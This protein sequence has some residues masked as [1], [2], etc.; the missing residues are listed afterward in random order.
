MTGFLGTGN[1]GGAIINGM[2]S[3]GILKPSCITVYD[4]DPKASERFLK[5]GCCI[6]RNE[7]TLAELCDIIFLCIKPQVFPD[8][9]AKLSSLD[10]SDKL[11]V[12]IAAGVPTAKIRSLLGQQVKIIRVMP[13]APLMVSKG[14]SAIYA[15][16]TVE[17]DKKRFVI[18]VFSKLGVVSLIDESQMNEI[19]CVN[20]SSPAYVYYFVDAMVESAVSQGID[21]DEAFKLICAVFEGSI[22]MLRNSSLSPKELIKMVCSPGGTTIESIKCFDADNVY[23]TIDDAMKACTKRSYEL[24]AD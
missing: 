23:K 10:L 5:L 14:A 22:E 4:A 13:N 7:A 20:G 12:T 3:S 15:P 18:D 16:D 21:R 8:V 19:V 24:G 9:L 17:E 1:M 6:A 11:I 2:L